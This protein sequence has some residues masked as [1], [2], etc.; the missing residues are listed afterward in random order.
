MELEEWRTKYAVLKRIADR[1]CAMREARLRLILAEANV[2]YGLLHNAMVGLYYNEP[3]ANVNYDKAKLA[4]YL[5]RIGW[6]YA[7]QRIVEK[8]DK[9]V[10][11]Y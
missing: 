4:H 2:S 9:R 3:W 5:I 6:E 8:W 11:G 7:P 10:R 1:I